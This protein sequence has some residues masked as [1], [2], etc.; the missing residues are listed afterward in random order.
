MQSSLLMLAQLSMHN[1][2]VDLKA[3]CNA[4]DG[5]TIMSALLNDLRFKLCA[6]K[7]TGLSEWRV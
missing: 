6:M 3:Q 1:I 2:C 7:A 4:S 5:R